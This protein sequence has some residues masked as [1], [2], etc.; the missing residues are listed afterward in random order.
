MSHLVQHLRL[1]LVHLLQH[2]V[3]VEECHVAYHDENVRF[4]FENV[5]FQCHFQEFAALFL[6]I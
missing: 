1:V 6:D 3:L 2:R 5:G 4:L